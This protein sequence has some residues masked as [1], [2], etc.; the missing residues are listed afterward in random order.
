MCNNVGLINVISWSFCCLLPCFLQKLFLSLIKKVLEKVSSFS[1]ISISS[2][3]SIFWKK[4][5]F[6]NYQRK[7][8]TLKLCFFWDMILIHVL[9][10]PKSLKVLFWNINKKC[11]VLYLYTTKYFGSMDW[12]NISSLRTFRLKET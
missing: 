11:Q 9:R 1:S 4:R 7:K 3:R 2:K 5:D 6:L 8:S 12:R 10:S